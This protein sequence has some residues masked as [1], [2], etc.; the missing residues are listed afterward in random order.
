MTVLS[1]QRLEE[2]ERVTGE[3]EDREWKE[4][5]SGSDERE[6]VSSRVNPEETDIW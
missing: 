3:Q 1:T 6:S 5:E 4:S 2:R